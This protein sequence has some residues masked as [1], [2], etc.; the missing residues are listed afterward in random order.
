MSISFIAAFAVFAS[1]PGFFRTEKVDGRWRMVRSGEAPFTILS[2]SHVTYRKDI[3]K[4]VDDWS[5]ETVD[6][7]SKWGFNTVGNPIKNGKGFNFPYFRYIQFTPL[8]MLDDPKDEDR[9]ILGPMKKGTRKRFPN[10]FN[11]QWRDFC[12]KAAKERAS[13]HVNDRNLIGYF[14]DNELRWFGHAVTNHVSG[15]F[16]VCAAKKDGHSAKAAL[17]SFLAKKGLKIGDEIPVLVKRDFLAEIAERYY[18]TVSAA[19]RAADPNHLVLGSRLHSLGRENSGTDLLVVEAC[20]RHCDV[21]SINCYPWVD[22]E[23]GTVFGGDP[24]KGATVK[25][26]ER[27]QDICKRAGKPVFVS[28]WSF[29]AKDSGLPC[30]KGAGQVFETQA[31][32]VR[33]AEINARLMLAEQGLIGYNFFKW[34]DDLPPPPDVKR[35][36]ENKNYGLVSKDDAPYTAL[37][38]MFTR[39]H[40]EFKYNEKAKEK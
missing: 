34:C 39:L 28:E 32:R 21:V 35:R 23:K 29:V 8:F 6:R 40:N 13:R 2:T 38:D 19:I 20:G 15:L 27:W 5:K 33:A 37:T 3:G 14:V 17:V 36:V 10:V 4:S 12:F 26:K 1:I 22:F 24:A 7:L 30:T 11:P 31:E 16:D 25:M 9:W 18:S